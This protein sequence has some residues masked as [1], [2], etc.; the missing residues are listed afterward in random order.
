MA[1]APADAPAD[2]LAMPSRPATSKGLP[3]GM[4][5]PPAAMRM[6]KVPSKVVAAPTESGDD[7]FCMFS[8]NMRQIQDV[9]FRIFE[10]DPTRKADERIVSEPLFKHR[11]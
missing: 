10:E 3:P 9:P 5:P 8:P 7:P 11:R 4:P 6:V 2:A 1:D